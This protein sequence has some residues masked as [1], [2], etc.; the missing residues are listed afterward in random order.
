MFGGGKRKEVDKATESMDFSKNKYQLTLATSKGE[1]TLDMWPDVAPGHVKNILGLAKTGF[2]DGL[3]FH[4]VIP[5]FVIQGGCPEGSGTGGPGY[6]VDAEFND[7]P[8]EAGVL[9]MARSSD[10]NSAGSQFFLCLDRVP[11]LDGQYTAFGKTTDAASLEVVKA[12]GAVP[13]DGH[14]KPKEPVVIKGATVTETPL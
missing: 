10:P 13:T 6:K 7:R 14:D 1:I 8:H 12:I 2:Y 9:S 11:Y 5:G 4:R 3:T